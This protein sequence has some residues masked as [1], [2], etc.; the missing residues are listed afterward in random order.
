VEEVQVVAKQLRVILT[1]K[2]VLARYKEERGDLNR[3]PAFLVKHGG[4][5]DYPDRILLPLT[6]VGSDNRVITA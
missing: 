5:P 3:H 4:C 1:G 6:D 2:L